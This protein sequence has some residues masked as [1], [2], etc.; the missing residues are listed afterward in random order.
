MKGESGKFEFCGC[1]ISSR[2]KSF[3]SMTRT[4]RDEDEES[5]DHHNDDEERQM[6]SHRCHADPSLP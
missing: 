5:R 6:R 3:S 4:N 1:R 2:R